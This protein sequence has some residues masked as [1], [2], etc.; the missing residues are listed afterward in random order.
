[1]KGRL[2][3]KV[4]EGVYT[5]VDEVLCEVDVG[6]K[7]EVVIRDTISMEGI[8]AVWEERVTAIKGKD[9]RLYLPL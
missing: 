5:P 9:G 1:M 6:E 2:L 7:R 3:E 8:Q 4:Q